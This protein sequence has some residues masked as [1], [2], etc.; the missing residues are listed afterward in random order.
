VGGE[1]ETAVT[2]SIPKRKYA[3]ASYDKKEAAYR[4]IK[5]YT[6]TIG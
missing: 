5:A 4:V 3:F 1:G 2:K 6:A